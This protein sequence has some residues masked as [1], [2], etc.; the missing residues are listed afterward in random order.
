MHSL[1]IIN[2]MLYGSKMSAKV[3][4]GMMK[5]WTLVKNSYLCEVAIFIIYKFIIKKL[6]FDI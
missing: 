2:I 4:G 1:K 6:I 3:V 5:N